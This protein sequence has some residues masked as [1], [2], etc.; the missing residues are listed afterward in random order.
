MTL[1][2]RNN[3]WFLGG[4]YCEKEEVYSPGNATYVST[5]CLPDVL[6]VI[7]SPR[8]SLSVFVHC[9]WSQTGLYVA[10]P[11]N[12]SAPT[13]SYTDSGTINTLW[14]EVQ[15]TLQLALPNIPMWM[16][17]CGICV[18]YACSSVN[19]NGILHIGLCCTHDSWVFSLVPRHSKRFGRL[20]A[21]VAVSWELKIEGH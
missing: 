3:L 13:V 9:K 4:H 7:R 20:E 12:E 11:G 6:H 8:P 16:Y 1:E 2:N 18:E 17:Q 15:L 14:A 19:R 5:F 10:S 21:R